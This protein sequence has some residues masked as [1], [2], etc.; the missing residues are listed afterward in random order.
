MCYNGTLRTV[1]GTRI[2]H[3]GLD[4]LAGI[5]RTLSDHRSLTRTSHCPAVLMAQSVP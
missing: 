4:T 1:P 5:A 2:S 3:S